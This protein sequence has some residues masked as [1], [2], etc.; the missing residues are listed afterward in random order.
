VCG[1]QLLRDA[2]D[3]RD[4]VPIVPLVSIVP[5]IDAPGGTVGVTPV[6]RMT[7][8]V[9]IGSNPH[10][11]LSCLCE[12]GREDADQPEIELLDVANGIPLVVGHAVWSIANK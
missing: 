3:A 5:I 6:E 2:R 1:Y 12:A 9:T 7:A 8:G 4:D 10:V 11:T